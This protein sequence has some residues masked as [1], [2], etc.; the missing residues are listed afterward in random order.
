VTSGGTNTSERTPTR[1]LGAYY[2]PP[3]I[4]RFM[5]RSCFDGPLRA[6][7]LSAQEPIRILDPACGDGAFVRETALELA[8][9]LSASP[10]SHRHR[11]S[12]ACAAIA[13]HPVD[14]E[15]PGPMPGGQREQTVSAAERVRPLRLDIVRTHVF[16]VDVDAQAIAR[17]VRRITTG[18]APQPSDPFIVDDSLRENFKVGNALTGDDFAAARGA[19]TVYADD[20]PH[21]IH[22]WSAF[23]QVAAAGGFDLVVGN[24]PYCREKGARRLFQ[25]L[26]ETELGRRWRQPRMDLWHYFLHRG[27]DLLRADGVLCYIV[28]AYWT[29]ARS[30][31]PVIE[32]LR[33]E[34]TVRQVVLLG[35]APIFEGVSGRHMI[36]QLHKRVS[37]SP[38]RVIDLSHI[39]DSQRLLAELSSLAHA[40]GDSPDIRD[41]GV[42]QRSLYDRARFTVSGGR[43]RL[44]S[45]KA[46]PLGEC[47]DVRQGIAENPPFV[48][49]AIHAEL[50]GE[51][52]VGQG[53][54]V[55]TG[56]ELSQLILS[57]EERALLRPYFSAHAV[58]RYR[59]PPEPTHWILYLTRRTAPDVTK[60]PNI[61]RHLSRVRPVLERRREVQRG[62]IAWWHLHWPREE[63]LFTEPRILAVQMCRQPQV[64]FVRRPTYV[65]FSLNIIRQR[66]G[67]SPHLPAVTAVLNSRWAAEW[68]AHNAKRRGVG[69]DISGTLLREFPL[70]AFDAATA[71]HL[72]ELSLRRQQLEA[73][74][75]AL[76]NQPRADQPPHLAI[77]R[78]IDDLVV[79]H[80]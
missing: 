15:D 14:R 74:T 73:D 2:T 34:T 60:L 1:K 30:A 18:D 78:E 59:L 37:D 43:R 33:A 65:G 42:P 50:G 39:N 46:S 13:G 77:E 38:C 79:R 3:P 58:G 19:A 9:R 23:P 21:D 4:V 64:V 48:T 36:L 76:S 68:F 51:L 11:S 41:Y 20:S 24:P 10:A 80:V 35:E 49:R 72:S 22:W 66:T 5:L 53:I 52:A 8:V 61:A 27:L 31:R 47:F 25:Q 7:L 67:A 54:F 44:Q 57:P 62:L 6:R 12:L 45:P 63:R 16:G 55:L 75:Q 71:E 28:N 32:R 56:E 40:D 17:L 29:S 26:A 69:L 70:P